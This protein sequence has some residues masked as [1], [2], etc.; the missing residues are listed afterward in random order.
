[1]KDRWVKNTKRKFRKFRAKKDLQ[2]DEL[3][4]DDRINERERERERERKR[5]RKRESE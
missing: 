2:R 4:A 1:M 5:E 3:G